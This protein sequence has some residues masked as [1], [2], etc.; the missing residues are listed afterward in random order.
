[1]RRLIRFFVVAFL[2]GT[3]AL[4]M[5]GVGASILPQS[6][7]DEMVRLIEPYQPAIAGWLRSLAVAP[8]VPLPPDRP[9]WRDIPLS[10][11]LAAAGAARGDPVFIRILKRESA[12][13]LFMKGSKGW[14]LVQT[15]PI[16]AWSGALGPKIREGDGQSPEGFYEVTRSALNP[17]SS[18][19]LSFNLGFPNAY[20][21]AHGRTGSFLMVHGACSSI[22]CYAM[23]DPAI[24]EIYRLVEAA[25]VKGQ[26]S[27][28]VHAFPFR[29][30]DEALAETAGDAHHAF[31]R[32]LKR[33][34]D[35]FE[36]EGAPPSVFACA[37]PNY[38]F[39]ASAAIQNASFQPNGA[40]KRITG[41]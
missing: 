20:D 40:C 30:T 34:W 39:E 31:W 6:W 1:M 27:V 16:C 11:R 18:Y 19:H 36:E 28:P 21:R 5:G 2:I 25:L 24:D 23:T 33:G 17:N 22:G 35:H 37:G 14:S 7:R 10:T 8:G 4:V 15:Y 13:E 38:R 41:L 3:S 32:N 9:D 26:G 29:M 12:L